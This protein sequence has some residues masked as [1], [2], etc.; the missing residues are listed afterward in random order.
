MNSTKSFNATTA[1]QRAMCSDADSRA[2]AFILARK[3]REMGGTGWDDSWIA[4]ANPTM[5]IA[6]KNDLIAEYNNLVSQQTT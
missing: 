2:T 5:L 3:I 6:I 4:S 1:G